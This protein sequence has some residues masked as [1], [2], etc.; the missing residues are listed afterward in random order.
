MVFEE[1]GSVVQFHHERRLSFI[2]RSLSCISCITKLNF[3][4][5][6]C[7]M[8]YSAH[9]TQ[10]PQFVKWEV[11]REGERVADGLS[12]TVYRTGRSPSAKATCVGEATTFRERL[13]P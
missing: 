11:Y 13:F 2:T 6:G 1:R 5:F 8:P 3:V 10:P 4:S 12:F 9:G 7:I